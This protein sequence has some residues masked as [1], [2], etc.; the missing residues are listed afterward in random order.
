MWLTPDRV[1][2]LAGYAAN[3][4]NGA[5]ALG[6][7]EA[8]I[9]RYTGARWGSVGQATLRIRLDAATYLL[10][11]PQ[12]VIEAAI[13]APTSYAGRGLLPTRH[14][15][16]LADGS[17][18]TPGLYT[19]TVSRGYVTIPEDLVKA[20]SL[21]A[22]HYLQLS[23]PERSRYANLSLGDFSGDMRLFDLPVPEAEQLLRPYAPA[24]AVS[25]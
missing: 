14:G 11:V 7:A 24:V 8:L 13:T 25:L 16:V 18:F 17:R 21:L 1:L 12:D 23:D 6:Y 15:L 19:L 20:A 22:A 3:V 2:P 9:E 4:A 5:A 10:P